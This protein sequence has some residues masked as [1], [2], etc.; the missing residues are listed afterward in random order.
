MISIANKTIKKK[1]ANKK[2]FFRRF[3]M[4]WQLHVLA[5]PAILVVLVFC[6]LPMYGIIIAFQNYIPAKGVF[7]S[8]W[9]WFKHFIN[10]FNDPYFYR[11]FK[12]TFMIGIYSLI[13]SFPAPI[14]LAL[15]LN[16]LNNGKFKKTIQTISYMPYFISTVIIVGLMKEMFGLTSGVINDVLEWIGLNRINFF[17]E[18]EWFRPLYIGSGIWTGIGYGS[19]IYLASISNISPELYESAIIDGAGRFRQAVSITI[20]SI[21]PTIQILFIFAVGG[22]LGN[23]FEKILLMYSPLI[24]ETSDVISTYV[25]RKGILGGQFSYSSAVGQFKSILSLFLIILTNY[26][27]RKVGAESLY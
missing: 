20:P 22:I 15:L 5:I 23:N 10:L 26:I 18:S 4:E 9:V 1:K 19:I 3:K 14:F 12:N 16:E 2:S 17:G 27:N 6:Y 7:G 25:Y 21:A 24:Y 8:E 11:I 13:L